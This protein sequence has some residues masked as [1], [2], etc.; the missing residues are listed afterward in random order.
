MSVIIYDIPDDEVPSE[1]SFGVASEAVFET[2]WV[3]ALQELKIDRLG[4]GVW[5]RRDELDLILADFCKV[6]EWVKYHC[7]SET[8]DNIIGHIDYILEKLPQQWRENP[9]ILQ[10]W[11]G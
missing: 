3:T 9:D 5:L 8:A 10:L 6:K 2:I 11:M 4:N 7:P 1:I